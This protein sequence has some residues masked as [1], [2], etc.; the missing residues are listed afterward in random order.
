VQQDIFARE[1]HD[2]GAYAIEPSAHLG[3]EERVEGYAE[4]IR[5]ASQ[6]QMKAAK[7]RIDDAS[8]THCVISNQRTRNFDSRATPHFPR[9]QVTEDGQPDSALEGL[10]LR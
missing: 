3:L 1:L 7:Q 8:A 2:L 5:Q 10:A 9:G 4:L 6:R